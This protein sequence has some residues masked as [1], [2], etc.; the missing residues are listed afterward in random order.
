[1]GDESPV[2]VAWEGAVVVVTLNRPERLN[3]MNHELVGALHD[4]MPAI[5]SRDRAAAWLGGTDAKFDR[6][7]RYLAP[8]PAKEMRSYPVS[9]GLNNAN[10]EHPDCI[11]PFVETSSMLPGF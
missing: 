10:W 4:R 5:L 11:K 2:L 7:C 9:R 1:M 8:F 6:L 3:A